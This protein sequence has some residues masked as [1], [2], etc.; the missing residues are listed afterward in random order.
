MKCDDDKFYTFRGYSLLGYQLRNLTPGM[1]DYLEMLYRLTSG[2]GYVRLNDLARHL[3][4]QPSSASKMIQKLSQHGFIKNEKYGVIHLTQAGVKQGKYLLDRHELLEE[5]LGYL[6]VKTNTL[7]DT[8]KIEHLISDEL[9]DCIKKFVK[10]AS[11]NPGWL[12]PLKLMKNIG[13]EERE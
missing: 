11:S 7:L 10:L 2:K 1:E 6:G 8:E 5:F 9:Y 12:D 3:N 4:V 13:S